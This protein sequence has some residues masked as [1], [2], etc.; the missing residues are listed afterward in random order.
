[1]KREWLK[2]VI[3]GLFAVLF[4]ALVFYPWKS[5]AQQASQNGV[6]CSWTASTSNNIAGYYV[7]RIVTTGTTC[8]TSGYTQ[9][10]TTAVTTTNYID[11]SAALSTD[12]CYGVQAVGSNG[13]VSAL[14]TPANITTLSSWPTVPN[15]PTGVTVISQ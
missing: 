1:M 8:P 12:Y 10:N 7:W 3:V 11:A 5:K 15:A 13:L 4:T 6:Y 9:L 14:S 2:E